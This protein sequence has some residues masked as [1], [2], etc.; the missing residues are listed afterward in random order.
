MDAVGPP[1]DRDAE[2][3]VILASEHAEQRRDAHQAYRSEAHPRVYL[4]ERGNVENYQK[5]KKKKSG[6]ARDREEELPSGNGPRRG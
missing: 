2:A 1:R 6:S 5:K 4:S 3:V